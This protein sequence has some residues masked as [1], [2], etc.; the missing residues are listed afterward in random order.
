MNAKK[1][2]E[3][4]QR[5]SSVCEICPSGY[6]CGKL[7]SALELLKHAVEEAD[8]ETRET[9]AGIHD[10]LLEKKFAYPS[11]DTFCDLKGHNSDINDI[12]EQATHVL[13]KISK[14]KL[15]GVG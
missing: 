3:L 10:N 12:I 9:C 7:H 13:K 4:N 2:D 8:E 6:Q 5:R 1:S 14:K 11:S 15:E